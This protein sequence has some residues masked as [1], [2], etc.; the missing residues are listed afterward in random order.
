MMTP[1]LFNVTAIT[2]LSPLGGIF[3]PSLSTNIE[4]N[5]E[6]FGFKQYILDHHEKESE[7][8]YDIEGV[9][10]LTFWLSYHLF[11]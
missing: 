6:N 7:E 4:F 10:L 2:G 5:F 3:K 11:C 8:F 9:A 1:T